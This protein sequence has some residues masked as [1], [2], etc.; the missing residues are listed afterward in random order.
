M[1]HPL[2]TLVLPFLEVAHTPLPAQPVKPAYRYLLA[3]MAIN[4]AIAWLFSRN[5]LFTG[6]FWAEG[7]VLYFAE[8]DKAFDQLLMKDFGYFVL[9]QRVIC[10]L[11]HTLGIPVT[12]APTLYNSIALLLAAAFIFSFCLPRFRCVIASD[13][14]RFALCLLLGLIGS[15]EDRSFINFTYYSAI[16]ITWLAALALCDRQTSPPFWAWATPILFLAKPGI[17]ATLPILTLSLLRVHWRF[18]AIFGLCIGAALIQLLTAQSVGGKVPIDI[19]ERSLT[20][21]EVLCRHFLSLLLNA[22]A[23]YRNT[24]PLLVGLRYVLA[25]LIFI[26]LLT[27]CYRWKGTE[28]L[29]LLQGVMLIF[30][31][32]LVMTYGVRE[33]DGQYAYWKAAI[34]DFKIFRWTLLQSFGSVLIISAL[35]MPIARRSRHPTRLFCL[36]MTLWLALS[37]W[38]YYIGGTLKNTHRI[39]VIGWQPSAARIAA[40]APVCAA[41]YPYPWFYTQQGCRLLSQASEAF[42]LRQGQAFHPVHIPSAVE[43]KTISSL[44]V[45]FQRID[46]QQTFT[47]TLEVNGE[48]LV[49]SVP[50]HHRKTRSIAL[51]FQLPQ[52][53]AASDIQRIRVML[54][55]DVALPVVENRIELN[56]YGQ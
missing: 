54:D 8:S 29:L 19:M 21:A 7:A 40:G 23:L 35:A 28:K 5:I 41:L 4:M 16:F 47:A 24:S 1:M 38:G 14:Q 13:F 50:V 39:Q 11:L 22:D 20:F 42:I 26:A 36:L 12:L 31:A 15:F 2:R 9:P 53:I 55:K 10:L 34:L 27:L 56:W 43:G 45:Y 44:L 51:Q 46:K 3:G 52:P 32:D 6:E 37:G 25:A 33:L 18:K 49:E 30:F 48:A 17:I